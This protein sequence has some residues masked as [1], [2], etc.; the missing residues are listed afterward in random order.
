M[1][2]VT[3]QPL[4]LAKVVVDLDAVLL[5]FDRM[6]W[7]RSRNGPNGPY[8]AATQAAAAPAVL[9]GAALEPHALVGKTLRLRVNGLVEVEVAFTGPDPVS[10]AAAIADIAGETALVVGTDEDGRLVLTTAATGTGASIEVLES[11]GA[12]ALGLQVGDA[13]IGTDADL[14]LV[15]GTH[16]YVYTDSNSSKEFWYRVQY[17]DSVSLEESP[18]SAPIPASMVPVLPYGLTIACFARIIDLRGRPIEGRKLVIANTFAPN[19]ILGYGVFRHYEE[20]R[21]DTTGLAE[22][23]LVRGATCDLHVEG[24]GFTR[25]ITLP[26]EGDPVDIVDLLDPDLVTEDEFGIQQPNIDFAIRTS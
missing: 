1:P 5:R 18:Y 20:V 14:V 12:L 4:D 2:V 22:I 8:E 7:F 23:R 21:T 25:R 3:N 24:T 11:E 26:A 9:H 6:R 15:A 13:A 17:R 16:D 10:T 19:R